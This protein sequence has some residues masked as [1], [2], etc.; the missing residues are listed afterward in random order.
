[1][2]KKYTY[3]IFEETP[4]F[5]K[6][7]IP[8]YLKGVGYAISGKFIN[9]I[10]KEHG[11]HFY[12]D[13]NPKK[14]FMFIRDSKWKTGLVDDLHCLAVVNDRSLR[15]LRDLTG[16]HIGMLENILN[17][18]VRL[19]K[20]K[21]KLPSDQ[22]VAYIH[23]YPSIWHLHIHFVNI[24]IADKDNK[25]ATGLAHNLEAVI[26]NLRLDTNYYK[27]GVIMVRT[28]RKYLEKIKSY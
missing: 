17:K 27:D 13:K 20:K 4:E 25:Q 14:G 5:Y 19:I 16:K 22:I 9:R 18:G 26:K 11:N 8:D 7:Y 10:K 1:M 23:Y 28:R 21:F 12:W 6:K 15:S 24:A 2:S 3:T